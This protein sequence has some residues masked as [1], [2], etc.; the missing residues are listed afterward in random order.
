MIDNDV[1]KARK[2]HFLESLSLDD[3]LCLIKKNK[4]TKDWNT[5]F[6]I[7]TKK[8]LADVTTRMVALWRNTEWRR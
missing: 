7:E 5:Q 1:K 8:D 4:E 2:K 6:N 3:G